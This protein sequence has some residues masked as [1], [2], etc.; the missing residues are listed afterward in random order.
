[1]VSVSSD[2]WETGTIAAACGGTTTLIDFVE[3]QSGERLLDAY[4]AR[5]EPAEGKAAIDYGLHMTLGSSDDL[6]LGQIPAVMDAGITSFK[7]YTTYPGLRLDDEGLLRVMHAV[8]NAGGLIL[9]H[10][11]NDAIIQ[12]LTQ[13]LLSAGPTSPAGH[14]RSRPAAA[15]SEAIERVSS[16]AQIAG[17]RIYFVHVST[18]RGVDAIARARDR[19]QIVYGE[20]CPHY[21][22]LT[23]AEYTRPEF[24]GAKYV[25]SPPLRKT[26]DNA[27]LW[28]ALAR[29]TLQS[30]GT[31]HC[32]FNF[33]GQK[34]LG[35]DR[36]S[37]IPSGLPGIETRLALL[38]S[39]GV[40]ENR[41]SV[42][43][44]VQVCSTAPAM[45]F[46]LYPR[47]GSLAV[48]SDADIV[49]FD[50]DV[51]VHLTRE[52]LHER[53]DYTPYEG[54]ILRGY[55][56]LTLS[57]GQVLSANGAYVGPRGLGRY[58]KREMTIPLEYGLT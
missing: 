47:K 20:T 42:N 55:P 7:T 29:G 35:R 34:E 12:W 49:V 33:R 9:T 19:G 52:R 44:W 30:V 23:D 45:L 54:F 58:L 24:E 26:H 1:H 57:K 2:D 21:L 10:A 53:V 46:G 5:R 40:C 4:R 27:A 37:E 17:A 11:E 51:K 38:Y 22:L 43:R 18:E 28:Q 31:D 14:P 32:P 56:V 15:E 13:R 8:A 16:L 36:F 25:C 3:P 50:P 39:S 6:V 48:G 41:L